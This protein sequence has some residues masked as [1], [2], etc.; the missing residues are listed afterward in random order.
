[1]HALASAAW[2]SS[3]RNC[4]AL[5]PATCSCKLRSVHMHLV[6]VAAVYA[7]GSEKCMIG[8]PSAPRR[9]PEQGGKARRHGHISSEPPHM[10]SRYQS[11]NKMNSVRAILKAA[12]S[13]RRSA[14][15]KRCA[16]HLTPRRP[17]T[18]PRS[19]FGQ[20]RSQGSATPVSSIVAALCSATIRRTRAGGCV[21]QCCSPR[22]GA[23]AAHSSEPCSGSPRTN[24]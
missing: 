24:N 20:L 5:R 22:P 2:L 9:S 18:C 19:V 21:P 17:A 11:E 1:M 16:K 4:A 6:F 13:Q 3:A 14:L 12:Q 7:R 10:R 23:S 8:L 15:H